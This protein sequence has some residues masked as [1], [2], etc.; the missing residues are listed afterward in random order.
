[1]QVF[2][3]DP[4]IY[5]EQER[6]TLRDPV[7]PSRVASLDEE[8]R[9]FVNYEVFFFA[10]ATTKAAFDADPTRWCGLVTDPVSQRRFYPAPIPLQRTYMDRLY[11]FESD[12]TFTAFEATP[13][14]FAVR[15]G[16]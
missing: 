8:L 2:G 5:L 10:D 4:E 6:I 7:D 3:Q 13:D 12:S 15:K 1:V 11:Y 9:T 14:S 16:M